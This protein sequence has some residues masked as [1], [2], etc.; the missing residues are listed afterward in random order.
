VADFGEEESAMAEFSYIY[1][2]TV[3][4]TLRMF[5]QARAKLTGRKFRCK[6]LA[7]EPG[8]G[9]YA[10]SDMTLSCNCQDVDGTGQLGSLRQNTFEELFAGEKAM[11]FR[12]ELAQGRLPLLRCAA[13][14]TLETMPRGAD[15]SE[16]LRFKLPRSFCIE[17]TVACNLRCRSCCRHQVTKTRVNGLQ[18]SLDDA[19]LLAKTLQRLNANFCGFYNLGEPFASPRIGRELQILR[20]YN[21]DMRIFISTNGHLIDTE[22][23]RAAALLADH[24]VFSIDGVSTE[25]VQRYQRNGNFDKAYGN[26]KAL[27]ALRDAEGRSKPTIDWKYV[28]FRWNDHPDTIR[29]LLEKAQAANVDHVQLTFARTPWYGISWRFFSPFYDSLAR[30]E[31]RFRNIRLRKPGSASS[32]PPPVSPRRE[33]MGCGT[34]LA[35]TAG[36]TGKSDDR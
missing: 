26:M 1:R 17:N 16:L 31:G 7:G 29:T 30:R 23:K 33:A 35:A 22:E 32:V 5:L 15:E 2:Q 12:Q 9:C 10:N 4:R 6:A 27:I 28:V 24:I 20:E 19:E 36:K 21:P 11:H 3:M 25:M 34:P 13:C 14:F 8:L 18:I